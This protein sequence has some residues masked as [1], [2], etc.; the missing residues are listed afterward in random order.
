MSLGMRAT[1]RQ[2][3]GQPGPQAFTFMDRA[4]ASLAPQPLSSIGQPLI[5]IGQTPHFYWPNPHFYWPD[6]S[7]LLARP[8]TSIG[9]TPL[10][11]QPSQAAPCRTLSDRVGPC[12]HHARPYQTVPCQCRPCRHVGLTL[13]HPC[14]L[15]FRA[16]SNASARLLNL[17][18]CSSFSSSSN[19]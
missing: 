17:K 6:P 4:R 16:F 14:N 13:A 1:C 2:G 10:F 8:L 12:R 3:R 7:L 18:R 9:Q 19:S 15:C 11:Y 5:S